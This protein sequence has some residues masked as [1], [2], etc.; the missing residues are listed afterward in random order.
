MNYI[1][2]HESQFQIDLILLSETGLIKGA[3]QEGMVSMKLK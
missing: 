3:G 1:R 2:S